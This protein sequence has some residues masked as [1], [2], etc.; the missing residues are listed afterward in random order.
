MHDHMT[1]RRITNV[2]RIANARH[3][4]HFRRLEMAVAKG[5]SV[6]L[7][8]FIQLSASIANGE[9]AERHSAISPRIIDEFGRFKVWSSNIG[10][11]RSGRSSLDYRL[12]DASH[13]QKRVLELLEDPG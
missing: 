8:A 7:K 12:R 5:A 4:L 10:A 3:L 9:L 2:G 13:I 11:H 1:P 6:C